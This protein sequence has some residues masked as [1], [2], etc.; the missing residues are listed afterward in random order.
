[1]PRAQG[2]RSHCPRGLATCPAAA[3]QGHAPQPGRATF[4]ALQKHRGDL[5]HSPPLQPSPLL[6]APCPSSPPSRGG[7]LSITPRPPGSH[8]R[9]CLRGSEPRAGPG[10]YSTPLGEKGGSSQPRVS[11]QSHNTCMGVVAKTPPRAQQLDS[12]KKNLEVTVE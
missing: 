6:P 9:V 8:A 4:P 11:V 3:G 5:W 1:M 2:R 12:R 10:A 7:W